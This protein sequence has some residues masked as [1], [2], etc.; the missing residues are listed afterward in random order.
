MALYTKEGLR[1]ENEDQAIHWFLSTLS[2]KTP[3]GGLYDA[4]HKEDWGEYEIQATGESESEFHI[5]LDAPDHE[6]KIYRRI[7]VNTYGL[8]IQVDKDELIKTLKEYIKAANITAIIA[9]GVISDIESNI[10]NGDENY[11]SDVVSDFKNLVLTVS[12]EGDIYDSRVVI[13]LTDT[14]N[15]KQMQSHLY[16]LDNNRVEIEDVSNV[17]QSMFNSNLEGKFDGETLF[18]EGKDLSHLLNYANDNDVKLKIQI[19]N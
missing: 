18:V 8:N 19:I 16:L 9:N 10:K 15:E 17:V 7:N 5:Y 14:V 2:E 4:L 13:A 1:F 3:L 6:E 12:I 11:L